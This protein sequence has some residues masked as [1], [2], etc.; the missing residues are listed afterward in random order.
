MTKEAEIEEFRKRKKLCTEETL[1]KMK[2]D[3][4]LQK[5]A[6]LRE[7]LYDAFMSGELTEYPYFRGE[8]ICYP[9]EKK[10]Y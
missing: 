2:S 10:K 4:E 8:K 5:N 7:R 3:E 1:R 9:T 6:K